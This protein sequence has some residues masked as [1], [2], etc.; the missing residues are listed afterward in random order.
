MITITLNI[1]EDYIREHSDYDKCFEGLKG[2]SADTAIYS[3]ANAL[4]CNALKKQVEKGMTDFVVNPDKM[5][6][7]LREL[8][9]LILP[10]ICGIAACSEEQE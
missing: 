2:E 9:E 8:Y 3:I 10:R 6:K 7:N 5:S 1:S 4:G